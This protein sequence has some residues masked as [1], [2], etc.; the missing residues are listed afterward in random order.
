MVY[1]TD[2]DVVLVIIRLEKRHREKLTWSH[3]IKVV[4]LLLGA[5]PNKTF[6]QRI[7]YLLD[8]EPGLEDARYW[9]NANDPKRSHLNATSPPYH[10]VDMNSILQQPASTSTD[11]AAPAP[12]Y[13]SVV[14]ERTNSGVQE[15]V[16]L[17]R[18]EMRSNGYGD[19][20]TT[21]LEKMLPGTQPDGTMPPAPA[22]SATS[23][24]TTSSTT[25]PTGAPA[26]SSP[27]PPGNWSQPPA[28]LQASTPQSTSASSTGQP[29]ANT[30]SW[31]GWST[32]QNNT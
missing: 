24:S 22:A 29:P 26:W 4:D 17:L 19:G 7:R 3:V 15:H 1:L 23:S 14:Q 30:G 21:P 11:T 10:A 16:S 28:Q 20:S 32:T 18:R 5:P 25:T 31:W 12:T 27:A 2:S 9:I 13:N 8:Q 6:K